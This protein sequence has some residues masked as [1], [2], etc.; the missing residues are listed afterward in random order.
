MKFTSHALTLKKVLF[1]QTFLS[2]V[3][4]FDLVEE[5]I[6]VCDLFAFANGACGANDACGAVIIPKIWMVV[7]DAIFLVR[8]SFLDY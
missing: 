2:L 8:H 3:F 4:I 1:I 6:I 5:S 7:G